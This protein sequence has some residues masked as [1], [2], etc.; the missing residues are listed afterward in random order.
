MSNQAEVTEAPEQPDPNKL[1]CK[2]VDV[3]VAIQ[4]SFKQFVEKEGKTLDELAELLRE[5]MSK[6]ELFLTQND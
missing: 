2:I 5:E 1:L 4:N 3:N 6:I